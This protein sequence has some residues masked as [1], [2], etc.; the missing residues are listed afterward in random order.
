[1]YASRR[2]PIEKKETAK[3]RATRKYACDICDVAFPSQANL[4]EHFKTQKHIDNVNGIVHAPTSADGMWKADNVA[5]R[6]F[7]QDIIK[8]GGVQC[9]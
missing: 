8:F 7:V 2:D 1:M 4:N 3:N 9:F 5:A 6:R